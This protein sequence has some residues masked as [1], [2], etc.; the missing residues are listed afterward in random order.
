MRL[1]RLGGRAREF[2][3]YFWAGCECGFDA[4]AVP[5]GKHMV[6]PIA[7]GWIIIDAGH[8]LDSRNRLHASRATPRHRHSAA[9]MSN[10]EIAKNYAPL[11]MPR[12][13]YHW[14]FTTKLAN[15]ISP[16]VT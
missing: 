4:F 9:S 16:S 2:S 7:A 11:Q 12:A 6:S 1:P 8:I 3:A 10:V 13:E 14:P 5:V 15:A